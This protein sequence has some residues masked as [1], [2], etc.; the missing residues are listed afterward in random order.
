[1]YYEVEATLCYE[2]PRVGPAIFAFK[3]TEQPVGRDK[4][5]STRA[6]LRTGFGLVSADSH[7]YDRQLAFFRISSMPTVV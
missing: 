2:R 5:G 3:T 6:A 1:M 4:A 7:F